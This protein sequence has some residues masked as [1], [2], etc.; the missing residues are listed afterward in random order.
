MRYLSVL[1]LAV[2]LG[3]CATSYQDN[4]ITK[5]HDD[6]RAKPVAVLPA[7]IDTTSFDVPWSI[8][9]ELTSIIAESIG[10]SGRIFIQSQEDSSLSAN[11]FAER[12]LSS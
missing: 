8:A 3:G 1:S 2:L 11:P 7:M 5:F 4:L 10:K 12:E 6:G 9:E